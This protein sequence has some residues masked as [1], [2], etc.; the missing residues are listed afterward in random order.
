[1]IHRHPEKSVIS[2]SALVEEINNALNLP[3]HECQRRTWAMYVLHNYAAMANAA[4]RFRKINGTKMFL[5]IYYDDLINDPLQTVEK[6]YRFAGETNIRTTPRDASDCLDKNLKEDM[7]NY[8]Q[9]SAKDRMTHRKP[10][11]HDLQEFGFTS[12]DIE[13]QFKP[14]LE[15]F[16]SE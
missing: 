3:I 9:Q 10:M 4:T 11:K 16:F 5:D 7:K 8:L 6:I 1:M 14:Y 12:E 2:G 13:S 15:H